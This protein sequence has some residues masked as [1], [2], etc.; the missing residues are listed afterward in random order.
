MSPPQKEFFD[1]F[2]IFSVYAVC[3]KARPVLDPVCQ[4]VEVLLSSYFISNKSRARERSDRGRFLPLSL[5]I[6]G[7]VQGATIELACLSVYVCNIRRFYGLREL[8]E[9][10]QPRDLW[11]LASI[12]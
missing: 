6:P 9:V 8:Y 10:P 4:G 11:R 5:I 1:H 3:L 2:P 7:W 12:G